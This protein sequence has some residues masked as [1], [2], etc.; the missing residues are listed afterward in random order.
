M[1]DH[2]HFHIHQ[3]VWAKHYGFDCVIVSIFYTL[4]KEV[5]YVVE[6]TEKSH[7]Y[8][9]R[10]DELEEHVYDKRTK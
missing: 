10:E 5:R 3:K 4:S 1:G 8:V 6:E 7:L 2:F 9:V